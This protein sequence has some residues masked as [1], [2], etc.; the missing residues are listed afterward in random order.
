MLAY[1]ERGT[2]QTWYYPDEDVLSRETYHPGGSVRSYRSY[3]RDGRP[4]VDVA[5]DKR[6]KRVRE[7][8]G[9]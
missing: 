7:V 9:R 6:G 4:K 3:Y 5:F 1:Y 8:Y 2:S